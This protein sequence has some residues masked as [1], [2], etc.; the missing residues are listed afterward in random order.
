VKPSPFVLHV[1][2]TLPHA[3]DL[4]AGTDNCRVLAGGQSLMPML[5]MRL[6]APDHLIDLNRIDE[7]AHVRDERDEIVIGAMTRQRDIEFSPLIATRLPL[8]QEA[9]LHVGHR[10][11]RNRGTVGGS[12]C[13]LD[14]AAE[15]P[16][17]MMAFDATL[18][19][20]SAR[21]SRT[22]PMAQ[23][24]EGMMT[25][26]L[27]ADEMLTQ[28]RVKPWP[29]SHG[30]RFIEFARR[31]GDFAVVSA[32]AMIE[33]D[34]RGRIARAALALGGAAATPLRVANVEAALVGQSDA[35]AIARA[36]AQRH[37]FDALGDPA[38]PAWYRKRL[39]GKLLARAIDGAFARAIANQRN[40]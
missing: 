7:L 38:F 20:Q 25:T 5:N 14:P 3:L 22:L 40:A 16:M 31:H 35:A 11:T 12:L 2:R 26:A 18:V 21:G 30:A 4:L 17:V 1:P 13:H 9:I 19:M 36:A 15:L 29:P 6:A 34:S 28:I 10:Q 8:L 23:F 37:D 24:A 33:L 32:A 27:Q 39:A